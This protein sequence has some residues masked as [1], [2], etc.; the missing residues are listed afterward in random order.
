MTESEMLFLFNIVNGKIGIGGGE[1]CADHI[2]HV[3]DNDG[4]RCDTL[5]D[6]LVNDM[7][8]DWLPGNAQQYLRKSVRVWTKPAA[9]PGYRNYCPH[10]G[11][12]EDK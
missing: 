11:G 6:D 8:Y 9:N 5:F 4:C 1:I 3:A 10:R 2:S 7:G 12:I